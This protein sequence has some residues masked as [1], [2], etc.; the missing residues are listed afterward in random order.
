MEA[1]TFTVGLVGV[2]PLEAGML[3][4]AFRLSQHR[5]R[6]YQML[7]AGRSFSEAE[8]LVVDGRVPGGVESQALVRIVEKGPLHDDGEGTLTPGPDGA[9]EMGR[10]LLPNRVLKVLDRITVEVLRYAPEL[11]IGGEVE[12]DTGIYRALKGKDSES[13]SD[14]G[15]G[16]HMSRLKVLVVDDSTLVQRQME[17]ILSG[18]GI[19]AD[20]AS[21]GATAIT[22]Y[23]QHA[24]DLVFLD[25]MMPGM[26]GFQTCKAIRKLSA[27]PPK[28]V[29]LTSKGS[30]INRAHGML[31]GADSYITKPATQEALLETIE[32]LFRQSND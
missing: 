29:M 1:R 3:D 32:R 5:P 14:A 22:M 11:N 21:D 26:D 17:L 25:V 6:A 31:V 18:A 28:V 9:F 7:G 4:R 12:A 8:I 20:F 23:Q 15:P 27:V 2:K 19:K 30:P 24:Y 16:H 13:E 10:P